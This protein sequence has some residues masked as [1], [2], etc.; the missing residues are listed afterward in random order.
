[1]IENL[2]LGIKEGN[3]PIIQDGLCYFYMFPSCILIYILLL[4]SWGHTI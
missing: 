3:N 1:M 2:D 4:Q